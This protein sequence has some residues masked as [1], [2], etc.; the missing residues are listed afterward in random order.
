[1]H[2]PVICLVSFLTAWIDSELEITLILR[3]PNGRLKPMPRLF[4]ID[5]ATFVKNGLVVQTENGT[6]DATLCIYVRKYILLVPTFY[7]K[8]TASLGKTCQET[9]IPLLDVT[10]HWLCFKYCQVLRQQQ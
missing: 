8:L 9:T 1:M 6:C 7:I 4:I 3:K 10:V 2:T 5:H